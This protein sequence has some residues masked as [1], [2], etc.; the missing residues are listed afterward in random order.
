VEATPP[1]ATPTPTPEPTQEAPYLEEPVRPATPPAITQSTVS[2]STIGLAVVALLVP[3]L[4]LLGTF[5]RGGLARPAV[6]PIV[7]ARVGDDPAGD[8][9]ALL[10]TLGEAMVDGGYPVTSIRRTLGEIAVANGI[11][12]SQAL[13]FPTALM[14]SVSRGNDVMTTAVSAGDS[15]LMLYQIDEL[16][17]VISAVRSREI[18]LTEARERIDRIRTSP[19]PY[20]AP[21]R[22]AAY[23]VLSAGLSVLLGASLAGV[24]VSAVLG[25]LVGG[26]LQ[27]GQ[28]LPRTYQALIVVGATFS[29][30][31]LVF[32]LARASLDPGMLPSLIAPLVI[33][34]PGAL[35]TTAVIELSTGQYMSGSARL[36]AG[37]MRLVLLAVGIVAAA[38]LVGIPSIDLGPAQQPLGA[39]APWVAVGLFGV[40]IAIHQSA[41]P[42]AIAWIVL[43]L[44]VAYG[45]QVLGDI[46]LGG[47]LSGFVG[48][49]VM[50][51]VAVLVARHRR[52]PAT[53]VSFLPAFW[54]LVP[55]ALGLVG[56]TAILDGNATGL[57]TLVTTASTMVAIALGVLLGLAI[58][59]RL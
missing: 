27:L 56:V 4:I 48:A 8:N 44:Y 5:R 23:I 11:E 59:K 58:T 54:L 14:V 35:L 52:G 29:V 10:V 26:L 28:R 1:P 46:L 2:W 45:A 38:A 31:V 3:A 50:T 20:S 22:L 53:I 6:L 12:W 40:G 57:G 30:S 37:A 32:L 51:P 15:D 7:P 24:A 19:P 9:V 36:A 33:L 21:L 25:L 41:R 17:D 39:F 18:T 13:V 47:V 16:D 43:V 34:L 42:S 49:L 55:G